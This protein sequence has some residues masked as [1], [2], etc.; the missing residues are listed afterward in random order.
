MLW[1]DIQ[2]LKLISSRL[3]RY[4]EKRITPFHAACRCPLCGDSKKRVNKVRGNFYEIK[5][6]LI[7]HCFNC[8]VH[9]S[10]PNFLRDFDHSLYDRYILEK[11]KNGS[12]KEKK[13]DIAE[14]CKI[15]THRYIPTI[16]DG[17]KSISD[18][19]EDHPVKQY[20]L[21]RRIP[22]EFFDKIFYAP[23]FFEWASGNTDRFKSSK[24]DH[25]RLIIPWYSE[26]GTQF[27][28]SARAFGKEM[29][30]YYKIILDET[31]PPYFGMD[32]V[33]KGK[34][35]YVVEGQL[36]AMFLPNC[37]S[38]GTSAIYN[39]DMKEHDIVYIPDRDVRNPDIMKVVR[40]IIKLGK[41]VCLLP[42]DLP[43]K[44]LNEVVQNGVKNLK[45]IIDCNTI[46]GLEAELKFSKWSQVK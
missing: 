20:V 21:N 17:L 45:E 8:E 9:I 14:K 44:D 34:P 13:V 30:K 27:A 26:D 10:F 2:Y 18:L 16:T 4:K 19:R 11:Y 31:Y 7:Y 3:E 6:S 25:P 24:E 32:R 23:K 38:V 28:Y 12:Q 33:E 22:E 41:K 39:F 40:K 37:V 5:G 36:D 42:L 35:I 46:Q 43:G 1:V 15:E 29:P